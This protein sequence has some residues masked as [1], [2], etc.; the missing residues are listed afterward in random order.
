MSR[1][2]ALYSLILQ[3]PTHFATDGMAAKGQSQSG[4]RQLQKFC[5]LLYQQI[6]NKEQLIRL[7]GKIRWQWRIENNEEDS[8]N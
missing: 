8:C 6:N 7:I 4:N 1:K 2:T 5:N 3:S